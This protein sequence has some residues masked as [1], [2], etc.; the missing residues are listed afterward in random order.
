MSDVCNCWNLYYGNREGVENSD[1]SANK[2]FC[3][4]K[5]NQKQQGVFIMDEKMQKNEILKQN[6]RL[7]DLDSDSSVRELSEL[8]LEAVAGAGYHIERREYHLDVPRIYGRKV[9][10]GGKG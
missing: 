4:P 10:P 9:L 5:T 8:E 2:F 7:E 3:L 1:A 6:L